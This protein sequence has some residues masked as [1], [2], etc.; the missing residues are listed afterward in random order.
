ME[1]QTKVASWLEVVEAYRK[2]ELQEKAWYMWYPTE[3]HK[4]SDKPW[5]GRGEELIG[6]VEVSLKVQ[7]DR[8]FYL[9]WG[10]T[11]E[12]FRKRLG[13]SE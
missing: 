1:E 10:E 11:Q 13:K 4:K 6:L 8:E 7:K 12:E 2:N 9:L 3:N 5:F